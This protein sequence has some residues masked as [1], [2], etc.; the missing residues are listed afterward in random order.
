[1][2]VQGAGI[3]RAIVTEKAKGFT[4]GWNSMIM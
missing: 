3:K 2:N 4:F 1:M